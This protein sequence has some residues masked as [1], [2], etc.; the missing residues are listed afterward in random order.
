[1]ESFVN[2][3]FADDFIEIVILSAG[4]LLRKTARSLYRI[5]V[6]QDFFL[7]IMYIKQNLYRVY[8]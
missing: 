6:L 1:M 4:I 5:N 3:C 8:I 2:K 7:W